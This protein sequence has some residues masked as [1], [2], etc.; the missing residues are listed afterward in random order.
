[1]LFPFN[2]LQSQELYDPDA[3]AFFDRVT[4]AGGTL[5]TTEKNAVNLLV[6]DLKANSLWTPMK[7]IYPMVGASA[8]ACAQNLKSSSFTG[9]FTNGWTFSSM[10]AT[11]SKGTGPYMNTQL[12]ASSNLTST[13][14]HNSYYNNLAIVGQQNVLVG[15]SSLTSLFMGLYTESNEYFLSNA[16]SFEAAS[17]GGST[18]FFLSNKQSA[19]L[20]KHIKNSTVIKSTTVINTGFT[21]TQNVFL[22]NFDTGTTFSTGSRCA[23]ASIGDGLTDTQASNFYTAVQTFNQTLNRQV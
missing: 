18:A 21:S 11:C 12:L 10:G 20:L 17:L 2:F 3:Q 15:D 5:T 1:M 16:C 6:L 23:F 7:A 14:S 19:T 22:N 4:T 9:T 13:S 8:A